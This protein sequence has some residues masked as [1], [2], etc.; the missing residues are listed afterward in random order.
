MALLESICVLRRAAVASSSWPMKSMPGEVPGLVV[1]KLL[2]HPLLVWLLLSAVGGIPANWIYVALI[3]AALPPALNIF[4]ISTQYRVG[5]ERASACI[6]VG[7]I[8]S[9]ITLPGFLWLVKTG[10]IAADL[11]H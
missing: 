10:R 1:I 2:L 11:F 3:M 7:T 8:V 5:V 9:M 4:V 6:L